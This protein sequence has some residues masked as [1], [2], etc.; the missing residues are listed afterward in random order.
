MRL[1]HLRLGIIAVV[2]ALIFTGI[3]AGIALAAQPHMVNAHSDLQNALAQLN[4]ASPDKAGHRAAAIN[5]VNEAIAQV[6]A[7]I[8]AG[9]K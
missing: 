8:A 4:A 9:A 5:Y 7:G 6:N 2:F 3:G 1:S